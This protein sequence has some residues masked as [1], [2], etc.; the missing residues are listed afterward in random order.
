[1]DIFSFLI[2]AALAA[3]TIVLA[4]GIYALFRGGDF[5]RSYSNKLMRL[6]VLMQFIAVVILV[7]AFWWRTR[8]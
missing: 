1:M 2:P 4:F 6:R 7:A 3:V 8:A 5:G